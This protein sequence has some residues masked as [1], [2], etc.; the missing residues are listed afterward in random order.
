MEKQN[1]ARRDTRL[2]MGLVAA[3][4]VVV[5]GGSYALWSWLSTPPP[6]VS[7]VDINRVGAA[8]TGR[9]RETPAYRELL[10]QY[11]SRG[12]ADARAKNS[13]FIA[14][15]P[16]E[17]E[18]IKPSAP[19]RPVQRPPAPRARTTTAAASQAS[20]NGNDK[21]G[22]RRQKAL[23]EILSQLK[24][25]V[26]SGDG[27]ASA[28]P[29]TLARSL[30]SLGQGGQGGGGTGFADWRG[31]LPG[32]ARPARASLG[33]GM[34]GASGVPIEVVKPYFRGPGVI[35]IG[36]D[37]DNVQTPVLGR[38]LSGPYAGAVFKAPDGAKLAGEGVVIHFTEMAFGG[39]NYRVDA[40]ALQDDTLVANIAS[41]VNHRYF[42]RI[43]L[44]SVFKGIGGIGQLYEQANTQVVTNGFNAI[45]TRPGTP[46]GKAVAGVIAGGTA[47]QAANV[48]AGDAAKVPP[49]Q[50]TVDNGQVV[51]IQFMR[52]VY[53]SDAIK[54][55][56]GREPVS[57]AIPAS[58]TASSG[59]PQ[60]SDDW[61]AQTRARIEAQRKLQLERGTGNE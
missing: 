58:R 40:Y 56:E 55:G 59:A 13:S 36:V 38:F 50:V 21:Q 23:D 22:E 60:T 14:S 24:P 44:P 11:N 2:L 30:D 6:S 61:R 15:I 17:S 49:L 57:P 10:G 53:Q 52:G 42:E 18:V 7:Q 39:V 5:V 45:T 20:N 3:G 31:S 9:A 19:T 16:L 27:V 54:P 12:V 34:P 37:S 8:S 25:R 43:V 28:S 51:A 47:N 4:A 41:N 1:D 33:T 29:L 46:D 32:G 48:L 26:T 35:D